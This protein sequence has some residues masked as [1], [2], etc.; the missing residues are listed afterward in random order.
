MKSEKEKFFN[1]AEIKGDNLAFA[2]LLIVLIL[3]VVG[4]NL[5]PRE[6]QLERIQ[7]HLPESEE[8]EDID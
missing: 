1:K 7:M 5:L 2:V 8:I 3:V 6:S 4:G